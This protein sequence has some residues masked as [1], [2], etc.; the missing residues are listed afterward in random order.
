MAG[1]KGSWRE[2]EGLPDITREIYRAKTRQVSPCRSL[3][4]ARAQ[5]AKADLLSTTLLREP[6]LPSNRLPSKPPSLHLLSSAP[7]SENT[8]TIQPKS[9]LNRPKPPPDHP[10]PPLSAVRRSTESCRTKR[11]LRQ[12]LHRSQEHCPLYL[13]LPTEAVTRWAE[14][15]RLQFQRRSEMATRPLVIVQ[16][17]GVLGDWYSPEAWCSPSLYLRPDWLSGLQR[18]SSIAQ[19]ALYLDLSRCHT[20]AI[21]ALL[22]ANQ[23]HVDAIY[24]PRGRKYRYLQ[25]YSQTISDFGV[26][27]ETHIVTLA[28]LNMDVS[29]VGTP[30]ERIYCPS[31]SV[32]ARICV[33]GLPTAGNRVAVV[34]LVPNPRAQEEQTGVLFEE[35]IKGLSEVIQPGKSLKAAFRRLLGRAQG[36]LQASEL[37]YRDF[38]GRRETGMV[39]TRGRLRLLMLQPIAPPGNAYIRIETDALVSRPKSLC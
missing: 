8:F 29:E 26:S 2:V 38:P 11:V 36:C 6:F 13:T 35:V 12:E 33:N 34:A 3:S 28:A 23:V 17:T 24:K 37:R 16:F 20:L 31:A 5:I 25:D 30:W 21:S 1:T 22:K 15:I 9:L 32:K 7:F 39:K 18:L 4:G 10:K 14:S 19:T 27:P